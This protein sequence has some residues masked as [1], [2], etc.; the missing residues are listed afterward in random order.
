[1]HIKTIKLLKCFIVRVNFIVQVVIHRVQ[2]FHILVLF[3]SR[4]LNITGA[5][6]CNALESTKDNVKVLTYFKRKRK[7][8]VEYANNIII[9]MSLKSR[10]EASHFK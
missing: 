9:K 7:R 1:M 6:F 2:L 3:L 5:F 10:Y 8:K 4:W